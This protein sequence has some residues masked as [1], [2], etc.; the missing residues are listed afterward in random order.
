VR[1]AIQAILAVA[2]VALAF[3]LY[4]TLTD[5]QKEYERLIA[6]QQD[7][8]ER[9]GDIR[10]AMTTYERR[11]GRYLTTLDSLVAFV[12]TDSTLRADSYEPFQSDTRVRP[13]DPDSMIVSPRTGERYVI[14]VQDTSDVAMYVVRDPASSDSIGALEPIPTLR[15]AASWE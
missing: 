11:E 12:K 10:T 5:P 1:L 15:N 14:A 8:R 6:L 9:M 13:F 4:R 2:V 3:V 7:S